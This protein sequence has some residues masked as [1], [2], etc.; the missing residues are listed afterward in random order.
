MPGLA[1]YLVIL[2]Q[3]GQVSLA[4]EYL[5]GSRYI[6]RVQQTKQTRASTSTSRSG[7]QNLTLVSAQ[8]SL[9]LRSKRTNKLELKFPAC[10]PPTLAD[11][12]TRSP[13]H[14]EPTLVT[15][16]VKWVCCRC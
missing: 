14:K 7:T 1:S 5:Q 4:A 11:S 8:P 10:Y 3:R 13:K 15:S 2:P 6:G 12:A 16:K 9:N